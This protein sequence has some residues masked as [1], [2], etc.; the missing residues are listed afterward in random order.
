MSR[1]LIWLEA[2]RHCERTA[3]RVLVDLVE[4]L[5]L[6]TTSR[7]ALAAENLFLRKQLALFQERSVR[8]HQA[9]DS[10][11]WLMARKSAVRLAQ[12]A[13]GG[14]AGY[15]DPLA[16]QGVP[17]VLALEVQAGRKTCCAQESPGVDREDGG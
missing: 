8:P 6:A 13:R 1:I 12:R 11:R 2:F 3:H 9:E 7:G 15:A 16:S 17:L 10:A 14:E 5:L 4:L